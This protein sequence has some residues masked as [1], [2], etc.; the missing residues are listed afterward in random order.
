VGTKKSLSNTSPTAYLSV[1]I[2]LIHPQSL[3]IVLL[4]NNYYNFRYAQI[5]YPSTN[6]T[7]PPFLPVVME[8]VGG[9]SVTMKIVLQT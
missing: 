9:L 3:A 2:N 5:T 4:N 6:K 7:F 1:N 8:V